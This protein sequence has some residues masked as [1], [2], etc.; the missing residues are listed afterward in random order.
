MVLRLQYGLIRPPIFLTGQMPLGSH[1]TQNTLDTSKVI[2]ESEQLTQKSAMTLLGI[3][4][5]LAIGPFV[6]LYMFAQS[7]AGSHPPPNDPMNPERISERMQPVGGFVL[8]PKATGPQT[9]Q[10]V[11]EGLCTSCHTAGVSGAPKIGSGDWAPRI[12]KGFDTLFINA[13]GG[14][15]LM[16]A[17]GGNPKLTDLEI[18]RAIVYMANKSGANFDEPVELDAD[19]KPI[20]AA[21]DASAAVQ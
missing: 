13:T 2:D 3:A 1:M 17:R 20:P 14:F 11:F 4:F 7:L 10:Q 5:T 16:P 19:G 21:A 6:L 9:G 12:A 8:I 15:N 18:K